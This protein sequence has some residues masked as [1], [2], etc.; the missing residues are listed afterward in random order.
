MMQFSYAGD[1]L[2]LWRLLSLS[3]QIAV[4]NGDDAFCAFS[5]MEPRKKNEYQQNNNNSKTLCEIKRM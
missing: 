5:F 1:D 2:W 4:R 3:P